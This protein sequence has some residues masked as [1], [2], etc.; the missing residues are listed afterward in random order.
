MA[1]RTIPISLEA[2]YAAI[3]CALKDARYDLA[4]NISRQALCEYPHNVAIKRLFYE[5]CW[6]CGQQ[7]SARIERALGEL[8]ELNRRGFWHHLATRATAL[9]QDTP[10]VSEARYHLLLA[11]FNLEELEEARRQAV[12]MEA[13]D[14]IDVNQ[15][16]KAGEVLHHLG[17]F[18]KAVE[19]FRAAC[20]IS[21]GVVSLSNLGAALLASGRKRAAMVEL[22]KAVKL[23]PENLLALSNL[24]AA[25]LETGH[26]EDCERAAREVLRLDPSNGAGMTN[27][28]NA[29]L[30]KQQW[31][32][33]A[34]I[35]EVFLKIH[36]LHGDT[37]TK[38]MYCLAQDAEWAR[39]EPLKETFKANV[40]QIAYGLSAPNPW[41][42]L[43]IFDDP[44]LHQHAARRYAR[45]LNANCAIRPRRNGKPG[46]KIHIGYFSADFYNHPTTQLILGILSNHDR[47]RFVIHAFSF[48]P[49]VKDD[50]REQVLSSVDFFHDVSALSSNEIAKKSREIGIDI[51]V[52][53][54]GY[55]KNHRAAIFSHRAAPIQV[56]YLGYPGTTML[57]AM[58]YIVVDGVIVPETTEAFFS[59]E[60]L[61]LPRCYQVNDILF[62]A[63]ST[64]LTK[65]E[66][67]LPEDKVILAC[68]NS[69]HKIQQDT[70][71]VWLD[72]MAQD[73]NS[74]LW[75]LCENTVARRN[76]ERQ[77]EQA[78]V[79]KARIVWAERL[80]RP[81]HMARH[82]HIDI[83]LDTWPYNAHTT[84]SDALRMGIPIVTRP[85]RSF[86]SRVCTSLLLHSKLTELVA[87]DRKEYQ[88][89][90]LRLSQDPSY[91]AKI[92]GQVRAKTQA[93][94]AFT[95]EAFTANLEACYHEI[96]RPHKPA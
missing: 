79:G 63:P 34:A 36:P 47:E 7:E 5:A 23:D 66:C 49:D 77:A 60:V 18:D 43:S 96:L 1:T 3:E 14:M 94:D 40:G 46:S 61:R 83:Y 42:L 86:A 90:I 53:L 70:F 20:A 75:L 68:F 38:L 88:E 95:A 27:L 24:A 32:E 50:Y 33:A 76:I 92:T 67:G 11:R 8:R 28:G 78:G 56:G 4:R 22:Q 9:L 37:M 10:K 48:G 85:G 72:V 30:L 44:E 58:D 93:A 25:C 29:L 64:K 52:D 73:E 71:H 21:S 59:E 45:R 35:F 12:R 81:Q 65:A 54:N 13:T 19:A 2:A 39:L 91:R 82:R 15:L 87:K 89:I 57:D 74:V 26:L 41:V 69:I 31:P 51:A 16:S 80:E 17:Y 62:D 6:E 84:A 55:T